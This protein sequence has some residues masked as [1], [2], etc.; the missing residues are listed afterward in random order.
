MH[1][2]DLAMKNSLLLFSTFVL[3]IFA[4]SAKADPARW[5]KHENQRGRIQ[6]YESHPHGQ[7]RY[8]RHTGHN[9]MRRHHGRG[10]SLAPWM[11]AAAVGTTIYWASSQNPAPT[12]VILSQ[13]LV[14][15][16]A[17]IAYFCQT[18]QQ[19]Y[20]TVPTCNVPWQL[21]NY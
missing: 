14:V 20:P 21:V 7:G 5:D 19:Y 15:D 18:A 9:H 2:K 3:I 13:P 4:A 11:A 8:D 16:P 6:I 1:S 17:R 10:W 12:T